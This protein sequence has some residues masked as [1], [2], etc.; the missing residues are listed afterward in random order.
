MVAQLGIADADRANLAK[1]VSA[2]KA[3]VLIGTSGQAGSFTEEVVRAMAAN[4]DR[5]VIL[6]MSNPTTICEGDPQSI[7]KW[8]EGKAL[9]ATGSPFDPVDVDGSACRIGQANNVFV[10]PGIGLGAIISGASEITATMIAASSRALAETL[11]EDDIQ[12]HSLMPEV[13]RLW[14]V[15]GHVALAV[16]RQA[17]EDRVASNTDVDA[18]AEQI[19]EYRWEPE[20]P[21]IVLTEV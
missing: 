5:P 7:L 9:V 4:T 10:F 16:A 19:A 11:S 12:A 13:S 1:V 8:T 6:P 18:L 20:Y 17:I 2:Y 15:C 14:D 3:T 21:E